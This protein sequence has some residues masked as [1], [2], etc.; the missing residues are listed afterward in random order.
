M[1]LEPIHTEMSSY[2]TEI[3]TI[4]AFVEHHVKF[5]VVVESGH[6]NF[7]STRLMSSPKETRWLKP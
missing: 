3:N 5:Y 4:Q 7:Q 6:V 1:P 2:T